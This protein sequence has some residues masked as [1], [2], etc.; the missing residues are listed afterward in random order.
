MSQVIT[1]LLTLMAQG[2]GCFWGIQLP[3]ILA[4]FLL[5][6]VYHLLGTNATG[7]WTAY[8]GSLFLSKLLL[9]AKFIVLHSCMTV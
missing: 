9:S 2:A 6:S 8:K 7:F 5:L 4:I 1:G 3:V